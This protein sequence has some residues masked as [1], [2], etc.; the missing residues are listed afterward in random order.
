MAARGGA[1][2]THRRRPQTSVS[3][4]CPSRRH[5]IDSFNRPAVGW[6][7]LEPKR[8]KDTKVPR[9]DTAL[10]L[11]HERHST[12]VQRREH[13]ALYRGRGPATLAWGLGATALQPHPSCPLGAAATPGPG[14]SL[15]GSRLL[16]LQDQ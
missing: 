14:P 6:A 1:L 4:T 15:P 16:S 13:S 2:S 10:Y 7:P 5:P 8:P 11:E 12:F 9:P 3:P